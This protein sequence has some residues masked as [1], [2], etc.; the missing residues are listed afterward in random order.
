MSQI[1]PI[2]PPQILFILSS[3]KMYILA[4]E[5]EYSRLVSNSA[6]RSFY[7]MKLEHS[8][9]GARNT[10]ELIDLFFSILEK[11]PS[12]KRHKRSNLPIIHAPSDTD[13]IFNS[14]QNR[15]IYFDDHCSLVF[16]FK[17]DGSFPKCQESSSSNHR[18]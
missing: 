15:I 1:M 17:H 12:A 10:F 8:T 6:H 7:T 18:L 4:D 9:V 3:E 14:H 16:V 5:S 13:L 2:C 11:D